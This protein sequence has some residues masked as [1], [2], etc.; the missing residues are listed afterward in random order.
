[1]AARVTYEKAN[2]QLTGRCKNSRKIGNHTYVER[3]SVD[4]AIIYLRLHKSRI[5]TL[6]PDGSVR[7]STCGYQTMTTKARMRWALSNSFDIYSVCDFWVIYDRYFPHQEYVFRDGVL[8]DKDGRITGYDPTPVKVARTAYA[9]AHYQNTK[10]KQVDEIQTK[11]DV[12]RVGDIVRYNKGVF[13]IKRLYKNCFSRSAVTLTYLTGGV[14]ISRMSFPRWWSKNQIT[15]DE[16]L[17][18]VR[19]TGKVTEVAA[20]IAVG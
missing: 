20:E 13:T 18:E 5:A 3:D 19:K 6:Y 12:F 1:M 10:L 17:S 9:K 8:I 16:F 14:A 2:S 15:K 7:L 11:N 4:P